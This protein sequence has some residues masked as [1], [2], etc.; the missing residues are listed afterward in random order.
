MAEHLVEMRDITKTFPGV[1]ALKHVDF[2]TEAG[3]VHAVV[4]ENGAGKSTLM[5]ILAGVHQPDSGE[6]L[7]EGRPVRIPS[8]YVAQQLGISI[9]H[10]ELNL[11]PDMT[12]AENVF[13]GREPKRRLGIVDS[14]QLEQQAKQVLHRLG[15]DRWWKSPRPFP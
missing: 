6:I 13:L 14:R 8:P 11:L 7:I 2:E 4:G 9:I 15:V 10:Q 3:E 1:V 12:V 5:K